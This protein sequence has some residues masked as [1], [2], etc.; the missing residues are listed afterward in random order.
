RLARPFWNLRS[1]PAILDELSKAQSWLEHHPWHLRGN[2]Q[3]D[4]ALRCLDEWLPE[5]EAV[6][7]GVGDPGKVAVGAG[8]LFG[9]D[10]DVG[11]SELGEERFEIV[12]AVVDHGALR[13]G[14]EVV[15][16]VG[17]EHPGGL[18]G[19]GG[20][21]VGPEETGTAVVGELNAEVQ[22]V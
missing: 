6:A 20:D 21:F 3:R 11:G 19:T 18:A 10:R 15:G 13:G 1:E 16:R 12:D 4:F 5:F 17:E 9:V 7:L 8:F 14:A 22:G 2:G